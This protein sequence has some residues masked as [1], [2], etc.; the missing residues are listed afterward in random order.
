MLDRAGIV[1][2]I[3]TLRNGNSDREQAAGP[4]LWGTE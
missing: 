4:W 3:P 1:P 2:V